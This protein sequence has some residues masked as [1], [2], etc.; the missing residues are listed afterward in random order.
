MRSA[1]ASLQRARKG[2]LS[3]E[4]AASLI[5]RT[6]HD[7]FGPLENGAGPPAGEREESVRRLLQD[8]QFIRYAPQLG[9]YSDKIREVARRAAELVRRRA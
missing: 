2:G 4:E 1:L 9:D 6:L 3:K 8:V 7:V 5:E